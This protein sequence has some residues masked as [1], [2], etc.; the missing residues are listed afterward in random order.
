M[1]KSRP[2]R[3]LIVAPSQGNYGGLEAFVLALGESLRDLPEFSARLCF[4]LV[5]E[6]EKF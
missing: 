4:K 5:Q 6:N 1:S 2:L 3:V